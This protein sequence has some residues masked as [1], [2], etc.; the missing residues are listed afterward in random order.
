MWTRQQKRPRLHEPVPLPP[1]VHPPICSPGHSWA[2]GPQAAGSVCWYPCSHRWGRQG[3]TDCICTDCIHAP[4]VVPRLVPTYSPYR[5]VTVAQRWTERPG[6]LAVLDRGPTARLLL[7]R[8]LS[9]TCWKLVAWQG[10]F[11][12][13]ESSP[14]LQAPSSGTA[15]GSDRQVDDGQTDSQLWVGSRLRVSCLTQLVGASPCLCAALPCHVPCVNARAPA[16]PTAGKLAF[17]EALTS[18]LC[19]CGRRLGAGGSRHGPD[20][21][22]RCP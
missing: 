14:G 21:A 12:F 1:P 8:C 15:L 13:G 19:S 7:T 2:E 16:A 11:F 18:A 3:G 17:I 20:A 10:Q 5:R 6:S 22:T 4:E 9:G